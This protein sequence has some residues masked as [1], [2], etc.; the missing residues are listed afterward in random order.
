MLFSSAAG[1]IDGAGQGNYA[2]ANTFLDALAAHRR[3][4]GLPATSMA[5]GLWEQRSGM[6]AHLGDA[7]VARMARAGVLPLSS[8]QGLALFDAAL[9]AADPVLVRPGWTAPRCVPGQPMP[10]LCRGL[11]RLRARPGGGHRGRPRAP[12]PGRRPAAR[13][14]LGRTTAA[15]AARP[16]PGPG[17]AAVLGHA[18]GPTV[19]RAGR[20]RTSASTRSTAGRAAQPR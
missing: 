16:G 11:A 12:A 3:A 10:A 5:W 18:S 2:A 13:P 17:G 15:S 7:D 9:A 4:L 19:D 8:D 6:T 1:V 14:T 20:P